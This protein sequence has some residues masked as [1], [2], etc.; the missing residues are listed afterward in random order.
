ME[1]RRVPLALSGRISCRAPPDGKWAYLGSIRI[2]GRSVLSP[3]AQR[4]AWP[5][6]KAYGVVIESVNTMNDGTRETS[7]RGLPLTNEQDREIRHYIHT[8]ERR[9]E[10]WDTPELQAMLAD[11][12][13]PPEVIDEDAQARDDSMAAERVTADREESVETDRLR[14]GRTR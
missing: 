3:P 4:R 2:D 7:F 12:L 1:S 11:M 8:K 9:G 10:P 5:D 14:P 13:N 6:R